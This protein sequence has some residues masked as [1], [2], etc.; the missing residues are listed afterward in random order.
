MGHMLPFTST[1]TLNLIF[2]IRN[3]PKPLLLIHDLQHHE[4]LKGGL[5]PNASLLRSN[6]QIF[7]IL[8]NEIFNISFY[9]SFLK[10]FFASIFSGKVIFYFFQQLK[11]YFT[12]YSWGSIIL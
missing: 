1:V 6:L 10:L 9:L 4:P 12:T 5:L 2:Y 7:G 3:H 8:E 11:P